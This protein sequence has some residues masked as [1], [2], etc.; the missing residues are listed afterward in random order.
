MTA[1]V[2]TFDNIL[3]QQQTYTEDGFT[4]TAADGSSPGLWGSTVLGFGDRLV[5]F[6]NQIVTIASDSGTF[7][8]SSIQ[9]EGR[10]FIGGS[11]N[12]T[13]TGHKADGTVVT[14]TFSLDDQIGLQTFNFDS[15]FTNLVSLTTDDAP[16]AHID[17]LV[18]IIGNDAPVAV[19]DTLPGTEDTPL[20]ITAAQLLGN[21]TDVDSPNSALSIASVTSGAGGTAVLNPNG[22]V[23]FTPNS[24][25]NGAANFTYTAT[26]GGVASAAATVTINVAAVNDAPVAVADTL[27]GTED[28]P[29]T[30]TAAQLLG[31]DTDV[32]SPNSALSIAS[33]TSGAGGTAV[34]NP[35]GT[36]SFTPTSNFNGAA[37]FTYKATDGGVASAVGTVTIN[38]APVND[39]PVI[40]SD[41]G[42]TSAM[43]SVAE[44]T[45]LVTTL[46]AAD[47]DIGQALTFSIYDPLGV[48]EL[49]NGNELHFVTAPDF[50]NLSATRYQVKVQVSDGN[51]GTDIQ[52]IFVNVT[53]V[54][55]AITN[56]GAGGTLFGTP[57][58]DL[59]D[60]QGGND[61]I[62]AGDGNDT[63]IGGL[64]SDVVNAG[65]GND[66]IV[67]T[68]GDGSSDAYNGGA[69]LDTIDMS[70]ITAPVTINLAQSTASSSQTGQ[71]SL[72][73][74]E[75]AIG[76]SG[77]DAIT[78]NGGDNRLDGSGGDDIINAGSGDDIVIGGA[79]NDTMNGEGGNDVFVFAAGF[80]ND[81]ILQFDA[82]PVGGQDHLDLTAFGIT[83]A[84]F[85]ARVTIADVG[86][87][88][89]I[90]IDGNAAQAIRLV[91]I[92][93][94]RT[95]T[96]EDFSLQ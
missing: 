10:A 43:K 38:I 74:I 71:D 25:F 19:A 49:R 63:I 21:D 27:F 8:V 5:D 53:D 39:R 4:I 35:N 87:D 34:L 68:I 57:G 72:S 47:P 45:T 91:G 42:G 76:G 26:D 37:N 82:N 51:G 12:Y 2:L 80:G 32:D 78:G 89:L 94:A 65:D 62:N 41:G 18:L 85:A 60:G 61:T 86:A 95:V 22:T 58:D 16:F 1:V 30:I 69:G 81:K 11:I 66:I 31:N 88:T 23:S 20:I 36:V 77:S 14:Q 44:H 92:D 48:F 28:T 13:F 56:G 52:T 17:N 3:S 9:L 46:A 15:Q 54:K 70:G 96:A 33:V 73:S 84:T 93:D 55:E 90:T 24:N 79:G 59:I 40:T 50:D 83:A 29:L 67:A 64:G 6:E 7:G 75:N